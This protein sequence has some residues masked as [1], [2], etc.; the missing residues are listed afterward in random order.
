MSKT[1]AIAD[2][3]IALALIVGY[4]VLSALGDDGNPLLL[5]LGGAAA[6]SGVHNVVATVAKPGA[7]RDGASRPPCER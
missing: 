4:I 3:V 7:A 2:S 6:R 5:I 1:Q